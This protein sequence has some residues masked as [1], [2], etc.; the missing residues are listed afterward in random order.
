ME[1]WRSS[2]AT[3]TMWAPSGE[4]SISPTGPLNLQSN[5]FVWVS[6][7]LSMHSH[8]ETMTTAMT[9]R[10]HKIRIWFFTAAAACLLSSCGF[11]SVSPFVSG[12]DVAYDPRLVGTWGD[13]QGKESAVIARDGDGYDI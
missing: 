5:P 11:A 12:T 6:I 7:S 2:C 10:H 3:T 13:P 9:R 1:D 4:I 8:T